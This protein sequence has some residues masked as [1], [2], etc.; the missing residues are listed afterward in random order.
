MADVL[1]KGMEIPESCGMC[2]AQGLKNA[3][4]HFGYGCSGD[5]DDFANCPPARC[6]LIPLPE[7]YG[8]L[9]DADALIERIEFEVR[10]YVVKD[11]FDKGHVA[12]W[13]NTIR[14]IREYAPTI[15]PAS[16]EGSNGT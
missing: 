8:R 13:N 15:I 12:G 4:W 14:A 2:D 3:V 6:P 11:E 7:K 1:I 9:I 16:E 5:I 10:H